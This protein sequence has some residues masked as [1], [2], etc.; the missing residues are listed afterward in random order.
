MNL[1]FTP[2]FTKLG[3]YKLNP[4]VS[5]ITGVFIVATAFVGLD[6][7]GNKQLASTSCTTSS[8]LNEMVSSQIFLQGQVRSLDSQIK[9]NN[10]S[11]VSLNA[12]LLN[13]N[14]DITKVTSYIASDYTVSSAKQK[15]NASYIVYLR[16]KTRPNLN[17]YNRY[18][19]DYNT[20]VTNNNFYKTQLITL[21]SEK[22]SIE[23]QI[24]TANETASTLNANLT[25]SQGDLNTLT[26]SIQS[27]QGN[28]CA[29]TITVGTTGG[30]IACEYDTDCSVDQNCNSGV[31][32]VGGGT[33]CAD[34]TT[35]A[36]GETCVA[37]MCV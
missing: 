3:K 1:N 15:S 16:N 35:C 20:L 25:K 34:S 13:K 8:V 19:A 2:F 18:S 21:N 4:A 29:T 12:S 28:M 36:T 5:I 31:C 9:A 24:T 37:G 30:G 7:F 14:T 23:S 10:D 6:Q 27:A 11:I 26:A 32:T 17:T 33:A 22:A